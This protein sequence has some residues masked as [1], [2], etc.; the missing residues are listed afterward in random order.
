MKEKLGRSENEQEIP[1]IPVS[2]TGTV[3][4]EPKD[5]S[6]IEIPRGELIPKHG[7]ILRDRERIDKE[8]AECSP[9][10]KAI[11][12]KV[13]KNVEYV[14][15]EE[16][17]N[18][19]REAVTG[20]NGLNSLLAD[21]KPYA[22]I[23]GGAKGKS[24]YWVYQLS[25]DELKTKPEEVFFIGQEN[26]A[27]YGSKGW[28]KGQINELMDKNVRRFVI[29]D[30]AIYS[31]QQM[32]EHFYK[33]IQNG[34]EAQGHIEGDIQMGGS[35]DHIESAELVIV[36]PYITNVA[37][38]ALLGNSGE[39]YSG[40]TITVKLFKS[41]NIPTVKEIL[42]QKEAKKWGAYT[43]KTNDGCALTHFEHKTPDD[44]SFDPRTER[45]IIKE[46]AIQPYR[47]VAENSAYRKS[48]K[49]L[50]DKQAAFFKKK[51]KNK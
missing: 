2:D 10:D 34:L 14:S 16:F 38:K 40:T 8:L 7:P 50:W 13:L 47:E 31:G 28:V 23:A 46:H 51:I 36:V 26:S 27:G 41:Q 24:N 37:E 3:S 29:F 12:K 39:E 42:T 17:D 22:I 49:A 33:Y 15:F 35:K 32:I 21:G 25:K 45:L 4:D 9:E 11:L 19:R 43:G 30:D 18:A 20:E 44:L 1:S 48:E 5:K 6:E